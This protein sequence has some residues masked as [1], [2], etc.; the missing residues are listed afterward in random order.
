MRA[1]LSPN[2]NSCVWSLE[3]RRDCWFWVH[4]QQ[5][6]HGDSEREILYYGSR[7]FRVGFGGSFGESL[8]LEA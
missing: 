8:D 7:V 1:P 5:G 6:T 4:D 2:C 3:R